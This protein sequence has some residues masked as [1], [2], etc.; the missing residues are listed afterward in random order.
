[1]KRYYADRS[2]RPKRMRRVYFVT[3]IL[4]LIIAVAAVAVRYVYSKDLQPVS[5]VS[6][7][8]LFTIQ[9]GDSTTQIANS[10]K[11]AGLIRSSDIFQWYASSK[12]VRT[13]L[14]A[15]TYAL[16][17]DM[18]VQTIVTMF[19]TGKVAANLVTILPGQR[20]DQ[21]RAAFIKD[22]FS[23][24]SVD[25]ALNPKL[26]T[27]NPALV[28]NPN[29]TSLEGFLYP[30]SFQKNEDTQPQVIKIGRAHV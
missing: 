17:P 24:A 30:D 4:F 14:Q 10:L 20:I 8:S 7:T 19:T 27:S 12:N 26:Y 21:I 6:T 25:A 18:S 23:Q 16:S 15:G 28:D 3:V 22:G 11:T 1:M 5:N 13:E 9:S 2:S 29:V